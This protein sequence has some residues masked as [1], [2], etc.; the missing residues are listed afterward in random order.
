M[1]DF[2]DKLVVLV[3]NRTYKIPKTV[4]YDYYR[5]YSENI[6]YLT[7]E[8]LTEIKKLINDNSTEI[9]SSIISDIAFFLSKDSSQQKDIKKE[10]SKNYIIYSLFCMLYDNMIE[11]NY[12]QESFS[13]EIDYKDRPDRYISDLSMDNKTFRC[14]TKFITEFRHNNKF[15]EKIVN[16]IDDNVP[17]PYVSY[18]LKTVPVPIVNYEI[19]IPIN[20]REDPLEEVLKDLVNQLRGIN[21]RYFFQFMEP[22]SIGKSR[23][24]FNRYYFFNFDSLIDK[25]EQPTIVNIY[26][27][28]KQYDKITEKDQ[29]RVLIHM[30][31]DL[32]VTG[33]D[34]FLMKCKLEPFSDYLQILE[35]LKETDIHINFILKLIGKS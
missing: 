33:N 18:D 14:Y 17:L 22:K 6:E 8:K 29:I 32:Y 1:D 5:K 4:S 21:K 20:P 10:N 2:I 11:R 25:K 34:K 35:N 13:L 27:G 3:K 30:L 28:R 15:L 12:K 26:D 24:L 7:D 19:P 31:S 23:K 16:L 9:D